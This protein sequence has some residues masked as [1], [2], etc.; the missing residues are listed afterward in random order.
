MT[1]GA[2][3]TVEVLGIYDNDQTYNLMK[4]VLV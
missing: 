1:L 3:Y 2:T 4:K